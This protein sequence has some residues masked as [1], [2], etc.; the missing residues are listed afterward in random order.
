M[1]SIANT[2]LGHFGV[3]K[4]FCSALLETTI[5]PSS[6]SS[7]LSEKNYS[8][9]EVTALVGPVKETNSLIAIEE[10]YT[11]DIKCSVQKV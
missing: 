6:S 7:S 11:S 9:F 1:D 2:R 8:I 4:G 5:F 3:I 10:N